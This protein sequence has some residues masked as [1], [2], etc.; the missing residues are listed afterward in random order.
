MRAFNCTKCGNR[1]HFEN[2]TCLG[3]QSALGFDARRLTTVA[4]PP[5]AGSQCRA[6]PSIR[7]RVALLRQSRP[8][9]VQLDGPATAPGGFCIACSLNRTIPNLDEPGSLVAWGELEQAKKRLIYA[10][11]R[12]GLSLD[13]PNGAADGLTF[14]FVRG[15]TTGH[16]EGVI[17]IDITEAD[18]GRAGTPAAAVRRAISLAARPSST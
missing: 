4:L 10:L 11:L 6:E 3:C 12:F 16:L 15:A 17:T 7:D 8:P 18:L 1:V 14:D 2:V 5:A 9:G 13:G